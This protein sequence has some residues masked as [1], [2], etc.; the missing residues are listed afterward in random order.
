VTA[1]EGF[2]VAGLTYAQA[3]TANTFRTAQQ[4]GNTQWTVAGV[5]SLVGEY[6]GNP[7]LDGAVDLSAL[8]ASSVPVSI[9][10]SLFAGPTGDVAITS[11]SVTA[12]LAP[13]TE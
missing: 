5:P 2:Y 10:I 8:Q 7:R 6:S 12:V 9:T 4:R 3:G 11:A 1:P 13:R